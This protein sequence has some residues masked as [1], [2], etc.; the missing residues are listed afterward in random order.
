L[1]FG[2]FRLSSGWSWIAAFTTPQFLGSSRNTGKRS[3]DRQEEV[4]L[5]PETIGHP[6]DAF[7]KEWAVAGINVEGATDEADLPDEADNAWVRGRIT[8][9]GE[10]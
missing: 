8:A 10:G 7:E 3:S 1:L 9:R 4:L 2:I 5:I 6:V